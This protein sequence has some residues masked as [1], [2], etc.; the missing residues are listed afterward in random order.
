M[1]RT[2][3]QKA[4]RREYEKKRRTENGDKLREYHRNYQRKYRDD[5]REELQNYW[6][7][8]KRGNSLPKL[9]GIT[10]EQYEERLAAQDAK[11]A[12]C[13]ACSPGGKGT[14]HVDH[15]HSSGEVRGILCHGCNLGLGLF[16]DNPAALEAAAD[17]LRKAQHE[18]RAANGA[19]CCAAQSHGPHR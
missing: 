11:C 19:I 8:H 17:Y 13:G 2:E 16:K 15:C 10:L 6:K 5:N 18:S 7:A 4:K 1:A 14:W 9:Y 12:I 3:E